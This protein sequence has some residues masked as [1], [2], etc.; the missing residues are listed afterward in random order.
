MDD[1]VD[2][3]SPK[4]LYLLGLD[5]DYTDASLWDLTDI[6]HTVYQS[7]LSLPEIDGISSE[8]QEFDQVSSDLAIVPEIEAVLGP[9]QGLLDMQ[10]PNLATA[11]DTQHDNGNISGPLRDHVNTPSPRQRL[12]P[13]ILVFPTTDSQDKKHR[14]R[15]FND[16]KRQEVAQ[17]RKDGACMRCHLNKTPV[18]I[19]F[20][21][22]CSA[23]VKLI[24]PSAPLAN[25]VI[26]VSRDGCPSTID[27]QSSNGWA[28]YLIRG[29]TSTS[30]C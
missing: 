3:L 22:S 6:D 25:H 16:T 19:R 30:L 8:L 28:A 18:R 12:A 7:S 26:H 10:A 21:L 14:R 29:K 1:S 20:V 27:R 23:P 24:T 5:P 17:V 4:A 9:Y 2:M 13:N 15:R 11:C